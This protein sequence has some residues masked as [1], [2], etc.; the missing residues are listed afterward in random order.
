MA[1]QQLDLSDQ[2]FV[3]INAPLIFVSLTANI[4]YACCL[5]SLS[6]SRQKLKQPL[7]TILECLDRKDL[8]WFA[9]SWVMVLYFMNNS[10]MCYVRLNFYYYVQ[11]VPA[12]RA[13]WIWLKRNIKSFMIWA[14]LLDQMVLLLNVIASVTSQCF[15][16]Y[17]NSTRTECS[18]DLGFFNFVC[19]Y[20]F[21]AYILVCLCVTSVSSFSMILY[22]YRHI[23]NVALSGSCFNAPRIQRHMRVAVTGACQGAVYFLYAIYYL[24]TSFSEVYSSNFFLG[25]WALFTVT[26]LFISGTTV[27]L[28]IGQAVFRQRAVRM[29]T[30]LKALCKVG[31]VTGDGQLTSG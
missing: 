11:I 13:L 2:A 30:A 27:N 8:K 16:S 14:F 19:F 17:P 22:L 31:M 25:Y 29:W 4:F 20:I 10:M 21:M 6:H 23:R 15:K 28:G 26:S 9:V 24:F 12:R 3:L 5:I 1:R 7:K 18:S